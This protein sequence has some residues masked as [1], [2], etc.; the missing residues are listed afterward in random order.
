MGRREKKNISAAVDVRVQPAGDNKAGES[1]ENLNWLLASETDACICM[2]SNV[3]SGWNSL[4]EN[5]TSFILQ[6]C[7]YGLKIRHVYIYTGTHPLKCEVQ[8]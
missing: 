5:T 6:A 7:T 4:K 8:R 1:S 3:A 2:K